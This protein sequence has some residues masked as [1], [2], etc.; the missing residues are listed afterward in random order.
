MVDA[1]FANPEEIDKILKDAVG[2]VVTRAEHKRLSSIDMKFPN[3][4]GWERYDKAQI[5]RVEFHPESST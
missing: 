4:D 2:C 3:I 5:V 1:I